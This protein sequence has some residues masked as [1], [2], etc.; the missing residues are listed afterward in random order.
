MGTSVVTT[1]A[2]IRGGHLPPATV[3]RVLA[4]GDKTPADF[5]V[6]FPHGR[7]GCLHSFADTLLRYLRSTTDAAEPA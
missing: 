7:R 1:G 3:G 2:E 4:D 6:G 5:A